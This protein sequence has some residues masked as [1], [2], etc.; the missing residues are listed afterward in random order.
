MLTKYNP[1][2]NY[3]KSDELLAPFD[4]LI[5]DFLNNSGFNNI[6]KEM[7]SKGSYPKCNVYEESNQL[8]IQAGVPGLT[9][10]HVNI[11]VTD[12]VLSINFKSVATKKDYLIREL[13]QSASTRSFFLN[14]DFD[15]NQIHASVKNGLLTINIKRKLPKINNNK[16]K[17]IKIQ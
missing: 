17:K 3:L 16:T 12:N 9:K 8:I 5:S 4:A 7:Y 11:E 13:K 2:K 14:E 15:T 1:Y 10:E 6:P